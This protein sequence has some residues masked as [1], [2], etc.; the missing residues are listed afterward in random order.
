MPRELRK[1]PTRDTTANLSKRETHRTTKERGRA[2]AGGVSQAR[3]HRTNTPPAP[4]GDEP[5]RW[6]FDSCREALRPIHEL[7]D[8]LEENVTR[9]AAISVINYNARLG[10]DG[11]DFLPVPFENGQMPSDDLTPLRQSTDVDRLTAAQSKA[12]FKGYYPAEAIP[13]NSGDRKERIKQA[14]GC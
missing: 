2:K 13:R 6:F 3:D 10:G 11:K 8:R 1:R 14:I 9:F 4:T 12:Y 5:P 7:L